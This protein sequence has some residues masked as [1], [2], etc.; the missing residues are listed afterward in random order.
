MA[1]ILSLGSWKR[2]TSLIPQVSCW[3]D[4]SAHV[5][6]NSVC[7]SKFHP[8]LLPW[9]SLLSPPRSWWHLR[10]LLHGANV[11]VLCAH[12]PQWPSLQGPVQWCVCGSSVWLKASPEACA[13]SR[14]VVLNRYSAPKLDSL[15]EE[16]P[17]ILLHLRILLLACAGSVFSEIQEIHFR[18]DSWFSLTEEHSKA[19][20]GPLLLSEPH[21]FL[22][23]IDIK[24]IL[25]LWSQDLLTLVKWQVLGCRARKWKAVFEGNLLMWEERESRIGARNWLWV[26]NQDLWMRSFRKSDILI[27]LLWDTVTNCSTV[28]RWGKWCIS[29]SFSQE[30]P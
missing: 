7:I 5:P 4:S 29:S 20:L 16:G 22:C 17:N 30:L 13:L 27:E 1:Q 25:S 19:I 9:P 26:P 23:L 18:I 10:I 8:V 3:P 11:C 6:Y 28:W 24:A 12:L 14:L 15:Q 21:R 2:D